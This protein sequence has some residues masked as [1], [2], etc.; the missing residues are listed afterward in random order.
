MVPPVVP[1]RLDRALLEVLRAASACEALSFAEPLTP[2]AG[3]FDTGIF[4]FRLAGAAAPWDAPLV[5]RAFRAGTAPER[6]RFEIALH[7]A[8]AAQGY[9]VPR[10][11]HASA[12]PEAIGAAFLVLER[13]PGERLVPPQIGPATLRFP[14]VLADAQL[15][16]HALD[17]EPVARAIEAAGVPRASVR[18]AQELLHFAQRSEEQGLGGLRP[19]LGW[20]REH[21]P[22][23]APEVVCHGDFHPLNVMVERGALSGVLDWTLAHVKL[24]DPAYD[25]GATTALLRHGPVDVPR[26]LSGV[27]HV[28]RRLLLGA[29]RRRYLRARALLPASVDYYEALRTL[30]CAIEAAE[31][32]MGELGRA[33]VPD[34]PTAFGDRTTQQGLVRR[35]REL[36]G[37]RISLP[38]D[39]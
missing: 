24:D 27:V 14:S 5:L 22:A 39:G 38:G 6:V 2:I 12:T 1:D 11:L 29:Y 23:R 3:G 10:V 26:A 8:I 28:A 33:P 17:P 9:P 32:R 30:G 19:G 36:T 35:F 37:T 21:P 31:H 4:G 34:K 16:L 7:A 20:L 18:A 25:V 15:R 13:V